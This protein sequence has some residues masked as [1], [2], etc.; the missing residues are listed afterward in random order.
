[1][2]L[3][4]NEVWQGKIEVLELE[5]TSATSSTQNALEPQRV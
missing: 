5:E 4:W 1:M 2:E 3:Q